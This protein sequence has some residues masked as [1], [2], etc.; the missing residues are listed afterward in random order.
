MTLCLCVSVSL[1]RFCFFQH[2]AKEVKGTKGK[3]TAVNE[4]RTLV[5][6][7][8]DSNLTLAERQ[9]AFGELVRIFQDMAYAC[10]YAR[11][12]DFSLAQDVAQ[13]AFISAWQRGLHSFVNPK[14]SHGGSGA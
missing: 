8:T 7:A 4:L 6:K 9:L 14:R 5:L 11:L 2:P 10:A 12:G 3:V 1:W 13:E